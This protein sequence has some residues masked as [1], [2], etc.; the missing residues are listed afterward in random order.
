VSV[1]LGT[2]TSSV[3]GGTPP[4]TTPTFSGAPVPG[5]GGGTPDPSSQVN[6]MTKRLMQTLAQAAQRKQFAGTPV[7]AAVPGQRDPNAARQIGMNTANPN[8]WGKQRFMSGLATS[9]QNAVAKQKQAKLLKAEADWTYLQSGLN[10]LYA[11]QASNDPKAAAAAQSKVD[12]VMGDPKKM[13]DM[14]KAL[15]QDWLSPEKTTVYGDALKKVNSKLD[16]TTAQDQQ[17]AQAAQGLKGMFQKL[18][19]RK[20]E[21]QLSPDQR[22]AMAREI[23]AKAPTQIVQ[24]PKLLQFL[25][26]QDGK[27]EIERMKIQ[28]TKEV[29]EMKERARKDLQKP[30]DQVLDD[31]KAALARGDQAGYA[32]K[33]KE[34]GEMASTTKAVKTP[35]EIE[36]IQRT[37]AGDKEAAAT[38]K[39][40]RNSRIELAKLRGVSAQGAK[41][42]T[43]FDPELKR[44]VVM[45]AGEAEQ[46]MK[47]GKNLVPTGAVPANTIIQ[48]Q[49]AA[50]AI[51]SAISEVEKHLKA[52]DDPKD[53]AIFARIIKENAAG[54]EDAATWMGTILNQASTAG[55]SEEGRAALNS[56]RRLN[57]SMGSLRAIS[58]L[59]STVGSMMATAALLPGAGT[60]DSRI[61]KDQLEQIKL[62]VGQETGVEL[63]G[64]SGHKTPT[65]TA[66]GMETRVYNGATYQRKKG[67]KEEWS[68]A[69][70]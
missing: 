13:K 16:Q 46:Q 37:N 32:A 51:P 45:G 21:P 54:S 59:P 2:P 20:Q 47:A 70:K 5:G 11:A 7:P 9:L 6:E 63:L 66:T 24:D 38:L 50:N 29:E 55:L 57:E 8:A 44:E 62:L 42:M 1:D 53:R 40:L 36:L 25:Q 69:P 26:T 15:N 31:A 56:L 14:A 60:P 49:R 28:A 52:W 39:D 30:V 58:G 27:M 41:P 35:N 22:S 61:A 33:L 43:F 4:I 3:P 23:E 68:L 12:V 17:K 19:Q 34:A 48:V 67:T 64:G 18:I 10:E 65:D